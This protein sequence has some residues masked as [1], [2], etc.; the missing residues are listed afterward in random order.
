ME[1]I[2]TTAFEDVQLKTL[3]IRHTSMK[4]YYLHFHF[5]EK[6]INFRGSSIMSGTSIPPMGSSN[7]GGSSNSGG[8]SITGGG[9]TYI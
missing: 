5:F 6:L 4:M 8:S 7:Q 3:K 2:L 9:F 1:T